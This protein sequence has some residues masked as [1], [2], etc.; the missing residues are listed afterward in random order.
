MSHDLKTLD[1]TPLSRFCFGAMQ[2][3]VGAD[4]AAS[5]AMYAACRN[6]GINFFD[7]AHVYTSGLSETW[8][9]EMVR[10]ERETV[11]VASKVASTGGSG[12]ANILEQFD[13][14][15]ARH[16]LDCVDG[17]YLHRYD[18]DTPLEETF[19]TLAGL[20]DAGKIRHVGVSNFA[21]W[22]T[23]KAVAV[24][25][26]FDLKIALMQPM[27]N[28]VKRQVEVEILPMAA[29]QGIAVVPYSPLGGG[30]LTGKYLDGASGRL[31][32]DE[33]YRVRYGD[34]WMQ[35]AAA[36][37]KS[38]AD[39]LGLSPATLAVAW[40]ASHPGVAAPIISARSVAQLRPSLDAMTFDMDA[41]LRARITA[42]T[43][44]LEPATGRS[45]ED[46]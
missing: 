23:M 14:S 8:L 36:E 43:P 17:L 19:E 18:P 16:K 2:F 15:R 33:R 39:E 35:D 22:Q 9:G 29:D 21:A 7:T 32:T 31:K 11:F 46:G 5:E 37:L 10:D 30:L 44:T 26:Q 1:G 20:R 38:L 45:E 27:Y 13:I 34:A 25:R 3:G 24:A 6:A 42:L 4:R 12:R 28:L 40:V 41:D